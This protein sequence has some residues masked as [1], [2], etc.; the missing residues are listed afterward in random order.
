MSSTE[1]KLDDYCQGCIA[2]DP[3]AMYTDGKTDE[4]GQLI[5]WKVVIGCK[6]QAVCRAT[7]NMGRCFNAQNDT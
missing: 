4:N 6:H 1:L 2:M 7:H 5:D 3:F